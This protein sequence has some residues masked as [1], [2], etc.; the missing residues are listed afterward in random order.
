MK[1]ITSKKGGGRSKKGKKETVQWGQKDS[2]LYKRNQ[3]KNV[4]EVG[5]T[6]S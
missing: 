3:H 6:A 5:E 4:A 1:R 2:R